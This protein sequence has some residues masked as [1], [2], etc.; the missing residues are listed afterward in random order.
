MSDG[1][2]AEKRFDTPSL[3]Y[4]KSL[5]ENPI[6]HETE[7]LKALETEILTAKD[8]FESLEK[9]L[10]NDIKNKLLDSLSRIKNLS[11]KIAYLDF[12]VNLAYIARKN[13]YVRASISDEDLVLKNSR[14]PVIE[15]NLK[16]TAF[17]ENDAYFDSKL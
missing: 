5:F 7:E 4:D 6:Y 8:R 13:K 11:E 2:I 16:D 17:I 1:V 15:K 3:S 12:I 14:H 10:F 9:E